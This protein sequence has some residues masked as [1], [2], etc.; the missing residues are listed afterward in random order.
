MV[1]HSETGMKH[2]LSC[3]QGIPQAGFQQE[4]ILAPKEDGPQMIAMRSCQRFQ[5]I[6]PN[7]M[8]PQHV[9]DPE[10]RKKITM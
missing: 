3:M 1:L 4:H 7:M 6:H 8:D 9:Q 10:L 5:T 2:F